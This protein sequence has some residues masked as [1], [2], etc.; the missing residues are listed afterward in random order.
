MA[1]VIN[2]R[3]AGWAFST[4][5]DLT[6]SSTFSWLA[7]RAMLLCT[8]LEHFCG[9]IFCREE[10]FLE[11]GGVVLCI[12]QEKIYASLETLLRKNNSSYKTML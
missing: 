12:T 3:C 11:H 8:T 1:R 9:L 7:P 4:W 6:T 5:G 10:A 2:P